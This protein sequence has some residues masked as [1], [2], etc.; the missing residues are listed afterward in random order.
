MNAVTNLNYYICP[1]NLIVHLPSRSI[2]FQNCSQ[3]YWYLGVNKQTI[4]ASIV[5]FFLSFSVYM[6][7]QRSNDV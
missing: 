2:K 5:P 7:F 6:G 4:M 1:K 3:V